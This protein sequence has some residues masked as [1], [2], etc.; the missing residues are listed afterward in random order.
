MGPAASRTLP[1][2]VKDPQMHLVCTCQRS[3][4]TCAGTGSSNLPRHGYWSPTEIWP[5]PELDAQLI[6]DDPV[7]ALIRTPRCMASEILE[8]GVLI[9]RV[10]PSMASPPRSLWK[11]S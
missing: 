5:G 10:L 7:R 9:L 2:A 11:A 1:S 8:T 3:S 4:T 6:F